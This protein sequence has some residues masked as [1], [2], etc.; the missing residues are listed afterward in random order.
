[1][2]PETSIFLVIQW[3]VDFVQIHLKVNNVDCLGTDRVPYLLQVVTVLLFP[4]GQTTRR[5]VY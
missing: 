5:T 2:V 3:E 1:M 4:V